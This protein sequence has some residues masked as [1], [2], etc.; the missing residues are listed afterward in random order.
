[1]VQLIL[2]HYDAPLELIS[3]RNH[4]PDICELY[5]NSLPSTYFLSSDRHKLTSSYNRLSD[6]V[7]GTEMSHGYSAQGSAVNR[8]QV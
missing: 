8:N 3:F 6:S 7:G 2:V 5:Q 1:M 4:S